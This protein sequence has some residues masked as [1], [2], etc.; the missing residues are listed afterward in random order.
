MTESR[1]CVRTH[2]SFLMSVV[3]ALGAALV[4]GVADFLG[5]VSSRRT[6]AWTVVVG[7][8]VCGLVALLVV[9]PF[10]PAA[11]VTG[12]DLAWGAAA[13]LAGAVGLTQFFRGFAIGS[14]AVVAPISA[15]VSGA[16]PVVVGTV[17]GE[18]PTVLAWI[19]IAVAL[20]AIVLISRERSDD[21]P[22]RADAV[23][24][25]VVAGVAFGFFF[26]F[27]DR[28]GESAGVAPVATARAAAAMVMVPLGVVTARL[29]RPDWKVAVVIAASG[30][31]DMGANVLFLYSVREGLLALGAVIVAMYP[32]TTIVL[33]RVVLHERLQRIQ[34]V[35]LAA[36]A[37]AVSLV[38]L[39]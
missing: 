30:I 21:R 36:A 9:M 32:A 17:L 33:A 23:I 27:I 13:G 31:L 1:R 2:S 38:A 22:A 29:A 4:Y 15:V 37:G 12:A 24:A 3:L 6:A 5:G 8:Q 35:G 25:A 20:P 19:G 39:S 14:M 10:L 16:V 34:L 11:T 28:S 7:A 26:V 18:R